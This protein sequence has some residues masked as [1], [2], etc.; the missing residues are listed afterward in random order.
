V[1][2]VKAASVILVPALEA[3]AK[4]EKILADSSYQGS[5][6]DHLKICYDCTLEI[7]SRAGQGFR[8]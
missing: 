2:D 6:G 1:A 5:L 7:G 4:I 3:N 8:G